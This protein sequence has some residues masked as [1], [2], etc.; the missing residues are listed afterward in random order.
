L[1]AFTKKLIVCGKES[2]PEVFFNLGL[3]KAAYLFGLP[4]LKWAIQ[5][6]GLN[7]H[8]SFAR[9]TKTVM[10]ARAQQYFHC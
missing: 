8:V 9:K 3:A 5:E 1:A 6:I 10:V 2:C 7:V 4:L